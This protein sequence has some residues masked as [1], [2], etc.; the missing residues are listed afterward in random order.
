MSRDTEKEQIALATALGECPSLQTPEGREDLVLH[1]GQAIGQRV[2]AADT[3]QRHLLNIVRACADLPGTTGIEK[4]L[5]VVGQ[6]ERETRYWPQVED[7]AKKL[8][9][10]LAAAPASAP[11]S[12]AESAGIGS[13]PDLGEVDGHARPVPPDLVPATPLEGA[14]ALVIGI[15][16]YQQQT[17]QLPNQQEARPFPHLDF[18]AEDAKAFHKFLTDSGCAAGEP[19][20]DEQATLRAILRSMDDLCR[21]SRASDNSL[22][23]IF[24]SGHGARDAEER[25]YLVPHD[26]MRDDLFATALWTDTFKRALRQLPE[27]RRVIVFV[28]ACHAAGIGEHGVKGLQGC[29]PVSLV[30]EGKYVVASCL[31]EQV[32]R[33]ADGHG[34]FSQELLQLLRF[35]NE[36]DGAEE[37]EL[38]GLYDALKQKVFTA[39]QGKQR[40][41]SNI[42]KPTGIVLAINYERREQ[43]QRWEQGLLEAVYGFLNV[44]MRTCLRMFI[45]KGMFAKRQKEFCDYFH[46]VALR[47]RG[48]PPGDEIDS[49]RECLIYIWNRQYPARD[50]LGLRGRGPSLAESKE[51]HLPSRPGVLGDE[52]VAT[53]PQAMPEQAGSPPPSPFPRPQG[54]RHRLSAEDVNWIL[55]IIWNP[56]YGVEARRL[57]ALLDRR[58]GVSL[59]EYSDWCRRTQPEG[60]EKEWEEVLRE[61]G[62]RFTTA[63][64]RGQKPQS[65]LSVRL[66]R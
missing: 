66:G 35:E 31:A 65:P 18:P 43:R 60:D 52:F 13:G 14:C 36:D 37:L 11:G 15:S 23:L 42:E 49:I 5:E 3:R 46:E 63:W 38:F 22:V 54:E 12:I 25:H 61:L 39:T 40:P 47:L 59:E 41:W 20:V 30:D 19:L 51:T 62:K 55:E 57:Q 6:F 28:D 1:L 16:K 29:D 50:A 27:T 32:S 10:K 2:R 7:C 53:V 21:Q 24:F 17:Y 8:K 56:L 44:E 45:D 58:E 64:G 26:G 33:E 9:V 48:A 34:I 4:L